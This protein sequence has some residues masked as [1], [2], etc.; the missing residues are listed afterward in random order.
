[1]N[2]DSGRW[3]VVSALCAMIELSELYQNLAYQGISGF[4]L[5][6]V[7]KRFEVT[8]PVAAARSSNGRRSLAPNGAL[9]RVYKSPEVERA[10]GRLAQGPFV[11]LWDFRSLEKVSGL[12][13]QGW[14]FKTAKERRSSFYQRVSAALKKLSDEL[15]TLPYSDHPKEQHLFNAVASL[16]RNQQAIAFVRDRA[17]ALFLPSRLSHH[18]CDK[19]RTAVALTGSGQGIKRGLS[20]EQRKQSLD[21]LA[22]GRAQVIVTTSAGNEGIDF[23][24][25]QKGFAYRFSASPTEALQQWG[26]VGRREFAGE[27][28]YLCSTPEEHGKFLS[29]LRKVAEFYRML[30]RERQEILDVYGKQNDY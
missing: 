11:G 21:D 17:H 22:A 30:N 2:N 3:K 8:F 19:E 1:M 24:R 28:T 15:Q 23:A 26:R 13:L 25:V 29:I 9:L 20:K 16:S 6:V 4:L 27:I 14:G 12:S 5:R 10:Y 18:G 7:E